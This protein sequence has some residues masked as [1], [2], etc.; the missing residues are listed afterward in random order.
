[1]SAP[2]YITIE[3]VIRMS[4]TDGLGITDVAANTLA[5]TILKNAASMGLGGASY[6]IPAVHHSQRADRNAAI[7]EEYRTGKSV[8]WISQ[9]Y[10]VSRCTV[11]RIT[12]NVS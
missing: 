4:L 6:Y 10:G 7:T 3:D 12:R 1:M 2:D 8:T 5:E 9:E 11:W